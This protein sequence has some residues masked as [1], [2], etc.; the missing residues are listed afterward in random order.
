MLIVVYFWRIYVP[1][2]FLT[3]ALIVSKLN[4]M[5]SV[6]NVNSS[7]RIFRNKATFFFFSPA[8]V[9]PNLTALN[10]LKNYFKV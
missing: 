4:L 7:G 5:K 3:L 10:C 1:K 8:Q 2:I 6:S 9:C